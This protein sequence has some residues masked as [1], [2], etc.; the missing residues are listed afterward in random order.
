MRIILD[1]INSNN[2]NLE[3]YFENN[4][5]N[6]ENEENNKGKF[7]SDE[8]IKIYKIILGGQSGSGK[9]CFHLRISTDEFDD[10]I[11]CSGYN[12]IEKE[13]IINNLKIRFDVWDISG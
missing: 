1:D 6:E 13:K 3:K 9:S 8:S 4:K 10:C 12:Y 5:D 11:P 7:E 2:S